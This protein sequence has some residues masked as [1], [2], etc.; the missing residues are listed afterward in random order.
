VLFRTACDVDQAAAL[1]SALDVVNSLNGAGTTFATVELALCLLLQLTEA[2]K[3][4]RGRLALEIEGAK[5]A[6]ESAVAALLAAGVELCAQFS[7]QRCVAAAYLRLAR[8]SAAVLRAQPTAV[9]RRPPTLPSHFYTNSYRPPPP[10]T[11]P[12]PP[13]LPPTG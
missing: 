2:D 5:N 7:A 11:P 12:P 6:R 13:S 1:T 4:T 3:A 10:L 9:R 8:G